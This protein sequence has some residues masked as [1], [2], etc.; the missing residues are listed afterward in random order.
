MKEYFGIAWA[1]FAS[2]AFA[3]VFN[4]RGRD[5][6]LSATGGALGWAVYL[7]VA[8]VAGTEGLAFFAASASVAVYSEIVSRLANRPA[9]TYLACAL[10]PLVPGGGMYYTMA[11]S[12][13]GDV[14]GS[15]AEGVATLST[16]GAIA[17]GVAI[18]SAVA[19]LARRL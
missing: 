15:L 8:D 18:G 9:T 11:R 17:A 7:L 6:P 13:T 16:A 1:L 19:R 2:G 12:L 10:I 3:V 4:V 14:Y 5:L